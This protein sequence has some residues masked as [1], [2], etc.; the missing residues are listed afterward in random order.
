MPVPKSIY[1][2]IAATAVFT[3]ISIGGAAAAYGAPATQ[4]SPPATTQSVAAGPSVNPAL[5]SVE[6]GLDALPSYAEA[7]TRM[8]FVLAA[9]VVGLFIAAK[10]L[11][12]YT[13]GGVAAAAFGR[14]GMIDVVET[15]GL[16]QGKRIHLIR[17]AG[18]YFLIG[19]SGDRLTTLAGG[20]LDADALD[21]AVASR[22]T[23][24]SS[25]PKSFDR[26]LA[27][28]PEPPPGAARTFAEGEHT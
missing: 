13:G 28:T 24:T 12:R 9:I 16:E 27:S 8:L 7:L 3:L 21:R 6:P 25:S 19:A 2:I 11:R 1:A 20:T 23:T 10:L 14:K 4:D 15:R 17:V 5:P 26:V 22:K 18:Q